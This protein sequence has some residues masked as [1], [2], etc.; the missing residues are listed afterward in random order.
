MATA[1]DTI[2]T[3]KIKVKSDI[4]E[5]SKYNVIFI[6]DE[7]TTQ[8]FVIEALVVIF[9]YDRITAEDMTIKIHEQGSGV[10]A[11]LPYEMA[12]QKG[13]ETTILARNNGFPLVVKL[14]ADS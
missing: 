5:P 10:V 8:D 6:N 2:D 13:V 3:P 1:S 7:I 12:E 14:E 9:N 11:T 4:Q